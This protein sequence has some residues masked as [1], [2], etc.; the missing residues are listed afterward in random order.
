M[1]D[2]KSNTFIGVVE[3]NKDPKKIGRCRIRV[4][5]IFDK[6]PKEDIPWATPWK[7]LNGN[8][9]MVPEVGKV[10]T[11]IFDQGNIYKPEYIYAE[12]YNLNLEDKLKSLSQQSNDSKKL[13]DYTSMKA[14]LF[15]HNTQIY[16]NESE[17]LKIDHKYNN[18]HIEEQSI[19]INL[20]DKNGTLNLGD[21]S[22]DQPI[23]LGKN[24]L[25]WFDEF[26]QILL[27]SSYFCAPPGAPT[28]PQP[29]LLDHVTQYFAKRDPHFLSHHIKAVDNQRINTVINT[30]DS[31]PVHRQNFGQAGDTLKSIDKLL[32]LAKRLRDAPRPWKKRKKRF[33]AKYK[34]PQQ[35][36]PTGSSSNQQGL[37]Q[38]DRPSQNVDNPD[39]AKPSDGI[40]NSYNSPATSNQTYQN[41]PN[42]APEFYE[43]EDETGKLTRYIQSKSGNS[44]ITGRSED[45]VLFDEPYILNI[46][47]FRNRNH[48]YGTIT[49]RFEDQLWVFF[50]NDKNQ[51]ETIRK[52]SVTSMPGHKV[53]DGKKV[54]PPVLPENVCFANYGQYVNSYKL[55]YH[56]PED[57]GKRH[58]ALICDKIGIRVNKRKGIFVTD[59][60]V[61]TALNTQKG[62]DIDGWVYDTGI[63][64][65][66]AIPL[67]ESVYGDG[68]F[69]K[70]G[71][72]FDEVN[73]WSMG[74]I[75]FNNPNQYREFLGL[76]EDQKLKGKKSQ[77]TVTVASLREYEVFETD[78]F[79]ED[80]SNEAL[81][82]DLDDRFPE[83]EDP[84]DY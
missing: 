72:V 7:D 83:F 75:V 23:I 71:I 21:A 46:I 49:N 32:K 9:F 82:D 41:N 16:V 68:N 29:K 6:I 66:G 64:I 33:D 11:V 52:F 2:L 30:S 50:K 48:E 53:V 39:F 73:S 28:V 57:Y 38:S 40:G 31:F 58:P 1:H 26:L 18:I 54:D 25:E 78:A 65:H 19:T 24:F 63:N 35:R 77:F 13:D 59:R 4:I 36:R 27:S 14:L 8:S 76:C 45:Y 51:W 80:D 84:T 70:S 5:N 61:N 74:C 60:Y 69:P 62:I 3:D 34:P 44:P 43:E 55:G 81:G 22:T 67:T 37:P 20:K 17:G 56:S 15:D 10:V 42:K 47:V 12:H 79:I